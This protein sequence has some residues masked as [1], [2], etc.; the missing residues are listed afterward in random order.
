MS[1]YR[2]DTWSDNMKAPKEILEDGDKIFVVY[3]TNG[4]SITIEHDNMFDGKID[5]KQ[6]I[7]SGKYK[8]I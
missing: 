5:L 8:L 6:L 4:Y 1:N 7:A 3:E 2:N